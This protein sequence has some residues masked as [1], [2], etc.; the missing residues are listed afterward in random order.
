MP[1]CAGHADKSRTVGTVRPG[2]VRTTEP[3]MPWV[4]MPSSAAT[5]PGGLKARLHRSPGQAERRPG[6][7]Q[8]KGLKPEGFPQRAGGGG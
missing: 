3:L 4:A 2:T 5:D 8:A 7:E 6:C 1:A